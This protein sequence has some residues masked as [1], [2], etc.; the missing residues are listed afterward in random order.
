VSNNPVLISGAS[1]GIGKACVEYFKAQ[2]IPVIASVKSH[3]EKHIWENQSGIQVINCDVTSI[4]DLEHLKIWLKE[5]KITLSGL[6]N[7]AGVSCWGP[8]LDIHDQSF[9]QVWNVNVVGLKNLTKVCLPH[10][11]PTGIIINIGSTAGK[12]A[13][14]F[15]G[16]YVLSK[17]SVKFFTDLLRRELKF[18]K[19]HSKIRV[20]LIEPGSINTPIWDKAVKGEYF[21][22]TT[23]LGRIIYP[24][25]QQTIKQ[26]LKKATK[27]EVVA[28]KIFAIFN[29]RSPSRY[30]IIGQ[31]SL[32]VTILSKLP[33]ALVDQLMVIIK[34]GINYQL[35]NLK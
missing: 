34:W 33:S 5:Q 21:D 31:G 28:K 23:E 35:K 32:F 29:S 10:L 9:N 24:L 15:M 25:G 17:S 27:P 30:Y 11:S 6:F 13:I 12:V 2:G 18:T 19:H 14:P 8:I 20:V 4:S 26:E 22:K 3:E 1:S 7:I 16:A